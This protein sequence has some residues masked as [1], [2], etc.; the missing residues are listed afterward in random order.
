M[1]QAAKARFSTEANW[2]KASGLPKETLSRLKK[3]NS[4]DLRTLGALAQT[5]GF[6]LAPVP[7]TTA[8]GEH[9]PEQFGREYEEE[10][11]DLSA[12]GNVNPVAWRA[13]GPAF[14]MGGLA[15]MLASARGF[16]REPYLRL[17]E[18][19]HPGVSTP[20]VFELWL[21]KSP[22]RPSRFLPMARKRRIA[23]EKA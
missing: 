21:G 17:A 15:V 12:S 2:A 20:E 14:F 9:L 3:Q 19:L 5:A 11:L 18:L 10:L 8:A 7:Q 22:V 16:S 13:R 6:T 23:R 1:S 4:C